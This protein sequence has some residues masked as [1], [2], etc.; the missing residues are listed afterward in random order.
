MIAIVVSVFSKQNKDHAPLIFACNWPPFQSLKI[1][2]ISIKIIFFIALHHIVNP[3]L[4]KL[5]RS[6]WLDIGLVLFLCLWTSTSSRSINMQK[7]NLPNIEP[8]WPQA[9]SI[10]HIYYI[11]AIS[12]LSIETLGSK[13]RFSAFWKHYPF[14]PKHCWFFYFFD[15]TDHSANTTLNWE[16]GVSEIWR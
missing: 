16:A 1:N 14:P 4:T 13:I 5:V 8:S 3:L 2:M 12:D 9:W 15:C 11:A 10:T 7:H 6:R